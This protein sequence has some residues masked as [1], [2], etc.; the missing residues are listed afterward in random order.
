METVGRTGGLMSIVGGGATV[1]R[2]D[3]KKLPGRVIAV[4]DSAIHLPRCDYIVTM[5]RL[6][7]EYRWDKIRTMGKETWIRRS[8]LKHFP[9]YTEWS[10]LHAFENDNGK[11]GRFSEDPAALNGN[12]SGACALNLAYHLRPDHL[13]VFGLDMSRTANAAYWYPP[14]PWAPNGA[15]K[16][17]K[18]LEW[19]KLLEIMV[20]QLRARGTH[21]TVVTDHQWS[22]SV[23]LITTSDFRQFQRENPRMFE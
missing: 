22:K 4:N 2:I 5:D 11:S 14:Y 21:V 7:T 20:K 3:I 6:W 16:D 15:T 8:V 19:A 10:D 12:N 1:K 18:Y 9:E 13:W 17:G 23:P